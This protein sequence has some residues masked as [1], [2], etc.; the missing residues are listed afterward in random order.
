MTEGSEGGS[1]GQARV[2]V[3][4]DDEA[5]RESLAAVLASAGHE[6]LAFASGDEFLERG[7]TEVPDCVLL[8]VNLPGA[9][10]WEVLE[11]LR[12]REVDSAVV[13]VSG[14]AAPRD[15]ATAAGAFEVLDKPVRPAILLQT[16]R[17]ALGAE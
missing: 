5:V 11:A 16:V 7:L 15:K 17:R 9:D 2:A 10:G 14:R 12:E 8:D 3:V 13:L 1:P 6:V 4:D